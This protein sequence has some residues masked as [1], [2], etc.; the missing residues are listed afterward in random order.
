MSHIHIVLI[1]YR[2][3]WQA[4]VRQREALY[5]LQLWI[6]RHVCAYHEHTQHTELLWT[7]IT[8]SESHEWQVMFSFIALSIIQSEETEDFVEI[9]FS[10]ELLD[11][12]KRKR[13][14][15]WSSLVKL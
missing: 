13:T 4:F 15:K 2:C 3:F 10:L 1:S 7:I 8:H 12:Y 11:I 14:K 9:V 5:I 6:I